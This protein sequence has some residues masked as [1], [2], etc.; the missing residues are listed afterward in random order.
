M[1]GVLVEVDAAGLTQVNRFV[2]RDG[3]G[4]TFTFRPAEHAVDESGRPL[5]ASHL[6]E[7]MLGAEHIVV[8]Y[9]REGDTLVAQRVSHQ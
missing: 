2:L 3:S 6:R 9:Q 4:T 1:S 5:N 8:E 7:H